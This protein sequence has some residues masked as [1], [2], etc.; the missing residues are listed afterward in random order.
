MASPQPAPAA[1]TQSM[2]PPSSPR[3]GSGEERPGGIATE[4]RA[5]AQLQDDAI[6]SAEEFKTAKAA[7]L[8]PGRAAQLR[9]PT[10]SMQRA[11]E[12]SCCNLACY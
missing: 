4:I 12:V 7:L 3:T 8:N 2:P 9:P 11:N 1:A 5:L 10:L 6:I